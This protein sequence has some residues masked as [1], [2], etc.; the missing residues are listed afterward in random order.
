MT[1]TLL[2]V[3]VTVTGCVGALVSPPVLL[4]VA[5]LLGDVELLLPP[6]QAV[7]VRAKAKAKVG[8]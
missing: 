5:G 7:K 1:S 3:L 4:V 6:P 8:S 2:A